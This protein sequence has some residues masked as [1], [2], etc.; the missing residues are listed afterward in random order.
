VKSRPTIGIL[1]GTFDP[2]HLGHLRMAQE[3]IE[4]LGLSKVIL[5]PASL[6]PHKEQ[7]QLF[8]ADFRLKLVRAAVSEN[9]LLEVSDIEIKRTGKSYS[10]D[11]LEALSIKYPEAGLCFIIGM[12]SYI[13][14]PSWKDFGKL[15]ELSDI[16]VVKRPG[17]SEK[18]A[19]PESIKTLFSQS[20]KPETFLHESGHVLSFLP[21][22]GLDISSTTIRLELENG[23]SI[24]YLVADGVYKTLE[25]KNKLQ[26]RSEEKKRA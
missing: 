19:P 13:E 10:V 24:R 12:D 18:S 14:L 5:I 6:P 11:T 26:K 3:A 1:G 23:N 7:S 9:P 25:E 17:Y 4:T 2:I 8:D 22:T 21:L 20:E 15:F 16:A